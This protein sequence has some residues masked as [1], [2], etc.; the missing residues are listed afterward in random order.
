[1]GITTRCY[2][3]NGHRSGMMK[4]SCAGILL[5]LGW[6][7]LCAFQSAGE[8]S[9]AAKA[10]RE[11]EAPVLRYEQ[12]VVTPAYPEERLQRYHVLVVSSIEDAAETLAD[13]P[14]WALRMVEDAGHFAAL[15]RDLL[16]E[17]YRGEMEKLRDRLQ[18][19]CTDMQRRSRTLSEQE[20]L[21]QQL[22]DVRRIMTTTCQPEKLRAGLAP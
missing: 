17:P 6:F 14:Q 9:S 3:Y 12:S 1:M 18:S 2:E 11:E 10:A 13:S 7:T 15:I 22:L 16:A 5:V 19:V 4:K 20:R 8:D 21:R